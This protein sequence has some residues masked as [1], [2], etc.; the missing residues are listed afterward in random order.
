MVGVGAEV[1]AT[2]EA[3]EAG[4]AVGG[5]QSSSQLWLCSRRLIPEPYLC[6]PLSFLAQL[7]TA[8]AHPRGLT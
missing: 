8:Q 3:G 7:H 2:E 5:G 1:L 6:L 4:E